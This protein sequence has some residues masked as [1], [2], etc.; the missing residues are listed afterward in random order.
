GYDY[1]GNAADLHGPFLSPDGRLY[2]CHGRKGYKATDSTGQVV[3]EGKSSGIWSCKPDGTDIQ[4]HSLLAGDNPVEVDFTPEG[5]V[6]GVQNLFY[7][8]PRGDTLVHWLKGG[9]YERADQMQVIAGLPRTLQHMPILHNFGHVAVSGSCFWHHYAA[10]SLHFLVTHFNTQRLVRTE[11]TPSGSSFAVRE[12]EFLTLHDP[13]IHLT[14]VLEDPRDGSL[15]VLN[16]GGWFRIGCPSSLMAKPDIAGAIYRVRRTSDNPAPSST[17]WSKGARASWLSAWQIPDV[18]TARRQ[19]RDAED[20]RAQLHACTAIASLPGDVGTLKPDLLHLLAQ[21]LD[22]PLEHAVLWALT[23]RFHITAEDIAAAENLGQ[24]RG[25]LIARANTVQDGAETN[26][27]LDE[28]AHHLDSEDEALA[29]VCLRIVAAHPDADAWITP[30]VAAWLKDEKLYPAEVRGL[31]NFA[32]ALLPQPGAQDLLARMLQHSQ[33]SVH[34]AALNALATTAVPKPQPELVEAVSADLDAAEKPSAALLA[35][36]R[37]LASPRFADRLQAI[38]DD[39]SHSLALRLQALEAM[40]SSAMTEATFALLLRILAGEEP[41]ASA[42]GRVQAATMLVHGSATED[43]LR[44][45]APIFAGLGP[46]ELKT[47][48]PIVRRCR[49]EEIGRSIA[50]ALAK[51]PVVGS[52][53]ESLFRSNFSGLPPEVFETILLPVIQDAHR[54]VE[55]RKRQLPSL[56]TRAEKEGDPTRGAALFTSGKGTCIACHKIDQTGREI[57]PNLSTIGGIRREIDLLESIL[58]PSQTLARDYETH[59]FEM[60]D[61]TSISGVI[62]SHTAEG[63]LVTDVAGQD[64]QLP[65]DRIQSSVQ[66][67]TS[68]MPPGLDATLTEMELLDLVAY[69]RSRK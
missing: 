32:A 27:L 14:D 1:T 44:A 53:E 30:K 22:A 54:R 69:L 67:E 8:K 38:A 3:F 35:A 34:D 20:P 39:P 13:G 57:G 19:L 49:N 21:P 51:N 25:L 50:Q 2:W 43:H 47:L 6:I 37:N 40:S 65:H 62:R 23:E 55:A 11:L 26:A 41:G 10:D 4:W 59:V 15:L 29:D 64:H 68:L 42:A 66:L 33:N 58:F 31:R 36:V 28:A 46:V 12:H 52:L 60:Q 5:D 56:A 9:V 48:L 61:G 16:T 63:L 7:N 24:L 18:D 45:M 17:P